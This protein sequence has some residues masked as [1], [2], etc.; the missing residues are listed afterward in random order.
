[1][2]SRNVRLDQTSRKQALVLYRALSAAAE[3][4]D[5]PMA[6]TALLTHAQNQPG[7]KLDYAEIIDEADFSLANESTQNKRA[8]IAGW[9]N[10]VRLID[11][12][13]MEQGGQR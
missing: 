8:I 11:N 13:K 6:R 10:G 3:S 2:S 12:M 5:F 1:M 7:F 9:L 4:G